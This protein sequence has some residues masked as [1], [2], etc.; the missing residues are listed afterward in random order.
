MPPADIGYRLLR[1]YILANAN[2]KDMRMTSRNNYFLKLAK[3]RKTTYEFA[4]KSVKNGDIKKI[5]EAARWA[6][7]CSNSQPWHFIVIKNR[8]SISKLIRI[9]SLGAFHT[10]PPLIIAIVLRTE[11]WEQSE[12]RCIK[13]QRLGTIE[14]YLSIAMPALNMILEA[15]D[16]GISSCLLTP[17]ERGALRVLRLK[18]GDSVP[19]IV[20]FGYEKKSVFQKRRERKNLHEIVSYDHYGGRGYE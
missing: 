6:P 1:I 5:L 18:K 14:A 15:E 17:E 2:L 8:K 19:L 3:S 12:H 16:L 20:G 9:S 4:D 13:N 10:D 11:C 7:S